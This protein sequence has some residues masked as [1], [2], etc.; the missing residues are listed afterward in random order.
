MGGSSRCSC[1]RVI[2]VYGLVRDTVARR[3]REVGIRFA[4]GADAAGVA[5]QY[6]PLNLTASHDYSCR[7]RW[8]LASRWVRCSPSA[9]C[10]S[11][12]H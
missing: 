4:L 8:P 3:S 2:G 1:L 12:T 9:P 7:S 6:A 5:S 10:R 11:A